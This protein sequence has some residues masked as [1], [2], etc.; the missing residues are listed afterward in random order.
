MPFFKNFYAGGVTSVRGFRSYTIG[1]KD[2][3]GN[4]RG[5][6]QK[7]VGN[8]EFLMPF[9][10]LENDRSVRMS[11]FTDMGYSGENFGFDQ[12]RFSAGLALFWASPLGP[13]KVSIAAPLR[14]LADDKSQA[15]QFT[16]GG[17][18]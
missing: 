2:S 17:L 3:D 12:L 16:I 13:L 18:F 11:V 10:G 5:G 7:L 4:P 14:K 6:S 8:A 15:F 1:P 9:P